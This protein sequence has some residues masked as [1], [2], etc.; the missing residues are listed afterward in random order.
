MKDFRDFLK[1]NELTQRF[2]DF[3]RLNNL[4]RAS[5]YDNEIKNIRNKYST[6]PEQ[7]QTTQN[8]AI[9]IIF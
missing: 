3:K 1:H 9:P 5:V 2:R 8:V 4:K 7:P 6:P